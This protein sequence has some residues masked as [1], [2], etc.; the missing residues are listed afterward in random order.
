MNI[1]EKL[2]PKTPIKDVWSACQEEF[3][4]HMIVYQFVINMQD[5]GIDLQKHADDITVNID[6]NNFEFYFKQVEFIIDKLKEFLT[7]LGKLPGGD[8][9]IEVYIELLQHFTGYNSIRKAWL[10]DHNRYY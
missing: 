3:K 9:V 2:P 7:E 10:E 6:D 8:K 4:I 5:M 1:L